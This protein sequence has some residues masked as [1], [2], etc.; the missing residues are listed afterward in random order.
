MIVFLSKHRKILIAL[1]LVLGLLAFKF[2]SGPRYEDPSQAEE[3][4]VEDRAPIEKTAEL[5]PYSVWSPDQN[6]AVLAQV[7]SD[8]EINVTSELSGTLSQVNVNIGSAV[9]E[10]QV[11]AQFRLANDPTQVSY[12]NAVSNLDAIEIATNSNI[13]SAEIALNNAEAQLER[14]IAQQE[15]AN[16]QS[17][18]NLKTQTKAAETTIS[19]ALTFLDRQ[20]GASQAYKRES[21]FGRSQVGSK[22]YLLTN[23][24]EFE[25]RELVR[26]FYRLQQETV[27]DS[28]DNVK[29]YAQQRVDF[30][31]EVKAQLEHYNTLIRDTIISDNFTTENQETIQSQLDGLRTPFDN[32]VINL[33]N[34]IQSTQGTKEGNQTAILSAENQVRSA[35]EQ[36]EI[37]KAQAESQMV[38]A[39]S[40]VSSALAAQTDL[41][42]RAPISGK[43]V[44]KA[45]NRGEQ[46]SFGSQLFTI[47]NDAA[48]KKVVAFLSNDEWS[49]VQQQSKI[50][51]EIDGQ[52]IITDQ[53]FLSARIDPSTQKIRAEFVLPSDTNV[54]VGS[55][56]RLLVPLQSSG[57]NL[58]PISAIAFEPDG[59]EVLKLDNQNIAQRQKVSIGNII[60]D[61]VQILGGL[62]NGDRIV[63]YRNRV[64]AGEK[65]ISQ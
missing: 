64:F 34:L 45:V 58:L 39:Q 3:I 6:R 65:I 8:N 55:F 61:S 16:D 12:L 28:E 10:G 63:K 44:E 35:R 24:T 57:Q 18:S 5:I 11:L 33:T 36:M 26:R 51:I 25:V 42:V 56:V 37:A 49:K 31:E 20:L 60:A 62:E 13:K 29:L 2:L 40:Q 41:T 30:I 1:L 48:A 47:V 21:V 9:Q 50:T 23:K 43:I 46:V 19:N 7:E 59:A 17:I 22:N 15:Q 4:I 38:G 52:T 14:T 27:D 53:R 32:L 54:L